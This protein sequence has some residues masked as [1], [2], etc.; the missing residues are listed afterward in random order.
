MDR[1]GFQRAARGQ[2]AGLSRQ[3]YLS[4]V[5]SKNSRPHRSSRL[6]RPLTRYFLTAKGGGRLNLLQPALRSSL[7]YC[8]LCCSRS[9]FL[10]SGVF[11]SMLPIGN[12]VFISLSWSASRF[13]SVSNVLYPGSSTRSRCLP[14]LIFM[15]RNAPPKSPACPTNFPSRKT[16]ERDGLIFSFN[17]AVTVGTEDSGATC[18]DTLIRRF[19]PGSTITFW[20]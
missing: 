1:R 3:H 16:A 11:C 5:F 12:S 6:C 7:I 14:G 10:I 17:V 20:T 13:T 9:G 8:L 19:S 2:C 4:C 15:D 18:S